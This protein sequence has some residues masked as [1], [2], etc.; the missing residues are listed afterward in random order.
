MASDLFEGLIQKNGK[1][2]LQDKA[3]K[4]VTSDELMVRHKIT[5]DQ[6]NWDMDRIEMVAN[7]LHFLSRAP[8]L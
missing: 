7:D 3:A 4:N 8:K 5:I 6:Y 2:P 1:L